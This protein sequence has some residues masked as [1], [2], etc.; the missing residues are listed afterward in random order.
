M[1]VS[2][3]MLLATRAL[4]INIALYL[5]TVTSFAQDANAIVV[6]NCNQI[7]QNVKLAEGAILNIYQDCHAEGDFPGYRLKYIWV[8]SM[9]LSFLLANY[10]H[11]TLAKLVTSTPKIFTRNNEVYSEILKLVNI[12]NTRFDPASGILGREIRSTVQSSNGVLAGDGGMRLGMSNKSLNLLKLYTGDEPIIW[13]DLAA[14]QAVRNTHG[15]PSDYRFA[16]GKGYYDDSSNSLLY[17][18]V[19]INPSEILALN[20]E[21]NEDAISLFS[22]SILYRFA[23]RQ[24]IENYWSNVLKAEKA[25]ARKKIIPELV[26]NER[27][28][29]FVDRD[30]PNLKIKDGAI[31]ALLYYTKENWPDDFLIV[32]GKY[33]FDGCNETGA[34]GFYAIP[35]KMQVLFAVIEPVTRDIEINSVNYGVDN[36][37][38]LRDKPSYDQERKEFFSGVMVR[39]GESIMI[40]LRIELK[41]NSEDYP[42][43]AVMDIGGQGNNYFKAIRELPTKKIRLFKPEAKALLFD[44]MRSSFGPP[45]VA[46]LQKTY[47]FGPALELKTA[48]IG[49]RNVEMTAPPASSLY[50]VLG[51]PGASCPFLYVSNN[52]GTE[53]LIGRVL[54]GA[55]APNLRRNQVIHVIGRR[56]S[57]FIAEQEPEITF[58]NR[59]EVIDSRSKARFRLARNL[60]LGPKRQVE[61]KLPRQMRGSFDIIVSGY[62]QKLQEVGM[63]TQVPGL[64]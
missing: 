18:G 23:R 21:R 5:S 43:S 22:C 27:F 2:G 13:F 31:D 37:R 3:G 19:S 53:R 33:D 8:N 49:G 44:K 28:A 55:N 35:R 40:P 20:P 45:Q 60:I 41:Y 24:D 1:F 32:A 57:L 61:F 7:S 26:V 6:G 11:P 56:S 52:D 17:G 42:V 39:R 25:I 4:L 14:S 29:S 48:Q 38:K 34:F 62:Y 10:V 9:Q 63:P 54:I 12:A 30:V 51:N 36:Q 16:Y 64:P 58:L 59:I 50:T 47:I 15:W 46:S